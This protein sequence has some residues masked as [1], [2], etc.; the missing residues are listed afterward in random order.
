MKKTTLGLALA[1]LCAVGGTGAWYALHNKAAQ[2]PNQTDVIMSGLLSNPEQVDPMSWGIVAN[3]LFNQGDKL[4]AAF[5]FY[6]FQV[7]TLPFVKALEGTANDNNIVASRNGLNQLLASQ[8]NEWI[9]TD[10]EAVYQ[11]ARQAIA[12]EASLSQDNLRPQSVPQE[13]WRLIV[14]QER[15]SYAQEMENTLG[16]PQQRQALAELRRATGFEVGPLKEPGAPLPPE[17]LSPAASK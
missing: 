1:A 5:C 6:V 14:A 4:R 11:V 10:P 12:Y 16:S 13:A 3:Q 7:R 9:A 2:A 17:W 15:Q 8:I